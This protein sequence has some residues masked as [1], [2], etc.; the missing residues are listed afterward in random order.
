MFKKLTVLLNGVS[1]QILA[2]ERVNSQRCIAKELDT[3]KTIFEN[4]K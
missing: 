3:T 2:L 1:R 4:K